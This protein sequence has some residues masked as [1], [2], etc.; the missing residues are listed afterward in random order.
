MYCPI[1]QQ[2]NQHLIHQFDAE[3]DAPILEKFREESPSWQSE[4]GA[5]T[6][7]VDQAQIES[8][9]GPKL[10]SA[11]TSN[12]GYKILPIA[13]RLELANTYT[14]KGVTIC[15]IDS[16]FYP[17]PDIRNRILCMEDLSS[18]HPH[19]PLLPDANSWHGTMTSVVGAGNGALSNGRYQGL[20]PA[21]KLVLLKVADDQGKISGQNIA[22]AIHWAIENQKRYKIRILNL[23]VTDDWATS[24]RINA[25]DQAIQKAH[26]AG[27]VVVVAA[28]NDEHAMLKAPANSPHAITI[29]GL[30]DHN[31]LH[32]AGNSWYPSTFG[33]TVDGFQKPDLIAPAIWIP[34][35]VLPG[36]TAHEE[37]LVLF[38]LSNTADPQYLKA[39]YSNFAAK[40]ALNTQLLQ[41]QIEQ[42][43]E[44]IGTE[45]SRRKLITPHYQHADGTSFAAPIVSGL[46]AQM[47]EANPLLYPT[48]IKEILCR[49]ARK[50]PQVSDERQGA[51]VVHA[52]HALKN[53]KKTAAPKA[54]IYFF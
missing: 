40:H 9:V 12:D 47:L 49:T 6:R 13:Q 33:T 10:Q 50:L 28:G 31:T 4:Q 21:A 1:C 37:A 41:Q 51:G 20:A 32:P 30:D 45:I 38:E 5:C 19:S 17:H 44:T 8:W 34:A 16:G 27:I 18:D 52:V 29:G 54:S 48:K 46:V 7:C 39:K 42:I 14:G 23:S 35:P 53:L 22:K 3:L 24:Y 15:F 26:Q 2:E 36:T 25:V 43:R 11:H